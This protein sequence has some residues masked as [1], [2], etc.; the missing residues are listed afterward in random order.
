M[1]IA[2]EPEVQIMSSAYQPFLFRSAKGTLVVNAHA[3]FQPG[4]PIPPRNALGIPET[5]VSHDGGLNWKRWL[6]GKDQGVGPLTEGGFVQLKNGVIRSFEFVCEGP[7]AEGV[8]TG[9]YWDSEDEYVTL[10]GPMRFYAKLP[11]GKGGMDDGGHPYSGL[12]FHRTVMTL[13][14]GDLLAVAYCWFKGDDAPVTYQPTMMKFR[15]VI[16]RSADE[17]RNWEYIS[18]VAHEPG[19]TEEGFNE[20]VMTRITQGKHR[21]RLVCLIRT[22]RGNDPIYQAHS[23]D[24]GRTWKD[25][26]PTNLLGV[27]PDL[28]EM[29]NGLLVASYGT[30]I[31]SNPDSPEHGNYLAFSADGGETWSNITRLPV[32][33]HSGTLR[34]TGYTGV[35]EVSPGRLLVIFDIGWFGTAIKYSAR[36]FVNVESP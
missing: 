25:L 15:T 17:G 14:G 33:P 13:P 26:H 24:E 12:T 21:G 16:L 32:E 22:G 28:T 9:S 20:P 10:K 19:T 27:D 6:P 7:S 3:E 2:I 5:V 29:S 31:M 4:Y 1:K 34:T 35:R 36:R 8:Y 11:Q 30:R 18:T 23:D